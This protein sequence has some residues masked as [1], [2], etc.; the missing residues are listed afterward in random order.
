MNALDAGQTTTTPSKPRT[1]RTKIRRETLRVLIRLGL[2][3]PYQPEFFE[4]FTDDSRRS[5]DVVVPM[6]MDLLRPQSVVDVGCGVGAWL[7]AWQAAGVADYLGLDGDYVRQD[8]LLIPAERFQA[9][10]LSHPP[11]IGRRFDLATSLEVAEHLPPET[12][13]AFV[14]A[15]CDLAPAVFFGAAVP[16]QGGTHHV[17]ERWQSD[18][19]A[20]FEARGYV[21]LDPVRPRVWTDERVSWWYAQNPLLYVERD[22]LETNQ[23]LAKLAERDVVADL[24]HPSLHARL[25]RR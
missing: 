21:A 15:L 2:V 25:A 6:L 19:A 23:A 17:N 24:V 12:S 3:N 4:G 20:R 9:A 14:Q 16:Q 13:D 18:W 22:M 5:A 8:Q 7:A 10:D 11:D 1:L